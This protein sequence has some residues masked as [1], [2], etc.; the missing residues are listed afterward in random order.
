M[1]GGETPR[2]AF[3]FLVEIVLSGAKDDEERMQGLDSAAVVGAALGFAKEA[4]AAARAAKAIADCDR[5]QLALKD[6]FGIE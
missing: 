4:K 3:A 5:Q 2:A 6:A 1:S